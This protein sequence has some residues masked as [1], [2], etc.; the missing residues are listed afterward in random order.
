MHNL[1]SVEHFVHGFPLSAEVNCYEGNEAMEYN[2]LEKSD[3][4][5]GEE[6][7]ISE[8]EDD[9]NDDVG[10]EKEERNEGNDDSGMDEENKPLKRKYVEDEKEGTKEKRKKV[11]PVDAGLYKPPTVKE[12]NQLRETEN[13]FHSNLFRLQIQEMLKEV[14]IRAKY[15][16]LFH[17]WMEDFKKT[18]ENI[19]EYEDYDIMDRNWLK[20]FNLK[21][22]IPYLPQIMGVFK[23]IK[24]T[25][26]SVVGSF[27]AGCCLGPNIKIDFRVEMPQICFDVKDYLNHKYHVKR[28]LYLA[29]IAGKLQES[30]LVEEM[31]FSQ[32]CGNPL[33]P[34]LEVK[35]KGKLGKRVI[36]LVHLTSPAGVF[37][38]SRFSP[39]KNNVRPNWYFKENERVEEESLSPTPH[40]N[41]S[42]LKDLVLA[43]NEDYRTNILENNPNLKDG[44]LLLKVWLKQR[45]LDQGYGCFSGYIM[46]MYVLYLLQS[47]RINSVMSSYQVAR[48]TWNSLAKSNWTTDGISLAQSLP[49]Q[50]VPN[51]HH[52]FEVV[53]IDVT[54]SCNFCANMS[55]E[56][57][58][59]V[60]QECDLA[61]K[62]LDN[63][64]INS[65]QALFM[66][67]MPFYR[68][69]DHIIRVQDFTMIKKLVEE[70]SPRMQ[71]LDYT[72]HVY[73]QALSLILEVLRKGLGQ[74]VRHIS[75]V[76][77][78]TERWQL[79]KCPPMSGQPITLGLTLNPEF[80]F[81]VLEKGPGANLPEAFE[82]R[83]F[84]GKKSEVRRFQDGSISEAVVWNSGSATLAQKRMICHKIVTYLLNEKF[85]FPTENGI[86]Y[87]ADQ[88]DSLLERSMLLPADFEYG[89]GEEA[90]VR[91]IGALDSL[92]KQ[93][94]QLNDIPLEVSAVQ[95]TSSVCRY[96][97]VFPPLSSSCK[98]PKEVRKEGKSHLLPTENALVIAPRWITPVDAIIQLGLSG[99]WPNDLCAIQRIKAAFYIK[100]AE[101]LSEQFHLTVQPYP[102]CVQ[103]LKDGFVFCLHVAYQR[104]ISLLKETTTP[105][106]VTKYRDT[107]ESLALEKSIVHLPKLTSSLHGLHQ[108]CSS[109]G[110]TCCLAKRWMSSQLLDPHHFP[111]M[112][113]E[114]LVASLYLM[115][116]P[117][118]PPNQPQLGF[119]RFLHL[120]AHTNWQTEPVI[121]NLN[122]EMTREDILEIET[123][124]HSHRSTLPPLF[125]STPYDKKNSIWTKEAPSLQILIR[126]AMLAGEALRVIESLLFSAI[127]SDW[128]Q[129]F[130]PS[131]EAFD[132]L[133]HLFPKLNSR[134]YEAVDVK[135]DKSNCQLQ[136]YLKEPGE[137]IP[138]TG[139]NPVNCFLAE[140]RENYSDYALFFYDMYGGN[141]IPVLWKPSALL[142]KD[143]KVSHINCHK[144]SKDGSKVELNVD[145]IIDDFYI[146]GKGVVSTIDVKSGSAL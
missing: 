90:T 119:F 139:F 86:I 92:G 61:V 70:H 27:G 29:Y 40:Y 35:P 13:L 50:S 130:R 137:K 54:G 94:R 38:L 55:K 136:S 63:P 5:D 7:N 80:A 39:E 109:Y 128:K 88:L 59:W 84:W 45:G 104:E 145:A 23:F 129:I 22:P 51:F 108:Q 76:L 83:K 33:K 60:K 3:M 43:A 117:Y 2:K 116:E 17:C 79:S 132:V 71:K 24:P 96:C 41:C 143:F 100:I 134:R 68:Q 73:P 93:L 133:I 110:P 98:V 106:G 125:L 42:I 99:K 121:L 105:E 111:E 72:G 91:V 20:E 120:L 127:K 135:S 67:S 107:E 131:L 126:A 9:E 140:L 102:D 16:T 8:D 56:T 18:L 123:W 144:P 87:V 69:F 138:V 15:R 12:L 101:G 124:F 34:V 141:I 46:C 28:A 52:H 53:F 85:G 1:R 97:D 6:D 113:I 44:I 103:I 32:S 25:S 64:N 118:Q 65:F 77:P 36:I 47:R 82:F 37:K 78:S 114:L 10:P 49:Q 66:T 30:E 62:C 57:F 11:K 4:D 58:L 75:I 31:Q 95:G 74:R 14:N 115:P 112:C 26:V 21:I 81:S 89:T 48:N 19:E 146:L 122:A 142:P